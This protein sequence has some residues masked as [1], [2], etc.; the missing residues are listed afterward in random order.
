VYWY[1]P[2]PNINRLIP[3]RGPLSGGNEVLIYGQDLDPFNDMLEE[4]NNHKDTFCR[5]GPNYAVKAT[6]YSD[7][8]ISCIAPPSTTVKTV[9]VDITLNHADEMLNPQD[10]TEDGLPYTYF[11]MSFLFDIEPRVGPT[12]GGTIVSVFGSN[13][14][15][16]GEFSCR[17][18]L[19]IVAGEYVGGNTVRCVSPV[20]EK[21]GYVDLSVSTYSDEFGEAVQ[22][23][24]YDTPFISEI[25]PA[26]GPITGN[27]QILIKGHSFS[28]TEPKLVKCLFGDMQLPATVLNTHEV[29]CSSPDISEDKALI[30][31]KFFDVGVTLN[32][33][34]ANDSDEPIKFSYY[35]PHTL[36]DRSPTSG[37]TI[38]GT[39]VTVTGEGFT[40]VGVCDVRCRFG[41]VDVVANSY[42]S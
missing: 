15:E 38:G 5:F 19:V 6:I 11:T 30:D 41:T 27:T 42:D 16:N 32:G 14:D 23:L 13:F 12:S 3:D 22:Y 28:Y 31:Q 40:Q 20:V 18:G 7:T 9:I 33:K 37:P 39:G 10:W 4:T 34:D 36:H 1:Y 29:L 26:C 35:D 2:R 25:I 24:Y 17:F 8:K 21:A